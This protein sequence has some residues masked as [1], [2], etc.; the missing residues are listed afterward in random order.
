MVLFLVGFP[1]ATIALQALIRGRFPEL[2]AKRHNDVA[3]F[4]LAVIGVIYA[5]TVGFMI[6]NQWENYTEARERTWHEAYTLASVAE[7]GAVL[8]PAAREQIRVAVV[9]YNQAVIDWWSRQDRIGATTDLREEQTLERLLTVLDQARPTTDAQRAYVE[10]ADERVLDVMVLRDQ[11]L[12]EANR[13]HLEAPLWLILSISGAV[14][15]GFCLLFGL[16]TQW[17][18]YIL[19]AGLAITIAISFLLIVLLNYPLSG[20]MPIA[21]DSYESVVRDL[22]G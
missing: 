10:Q 16:E 15:V 13:A 17:L 11:R 18:H 8:D 21:P 3:G 6:A 22:S 7:G 14:T 5:V 19:V 1:A 2:K 9:D 12:H 20:V 4:L